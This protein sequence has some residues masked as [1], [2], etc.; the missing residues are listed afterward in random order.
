MSILR[1]SQFTRIVVLFLF[2]LGGFSYEWFAV[3]SYKEDYEIRRWCKNDQ[4]RSADS[5]C[6][7]CG[8]IHSRINH[9]F[10]VTNRRKSTTN[11]T[12]SIRRI[13]FRFFFE[14]VLFVSSVMMLQQRFRKMN[15]SIFSS[16]LFHEKKPQKH[17]RKKNRLVRCN[18][19]SHC[20]HQVDL[21]I[22]FNY[23]V[24]IP[25]R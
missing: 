6:Q 8:I 14:D 10:M 24:S 7:S 15:Y 21:A 12:G 2:F 13:E 17:I 3:S 25:C 16:I 5:F 22:R 19:S 23:R 20:R 4:C 18:T 9:P 11:I 1:L